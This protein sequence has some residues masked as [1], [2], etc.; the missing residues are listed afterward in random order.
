MGFEEVPQQAVRA[1][2][3]KVRGSLSGVPSGVSGPGS[4]RFL[5][6]A[7]M[8]G[9]TDFVYREVMTALFGGRSGI[10][11]C[12]CEFIRV[13]DRLLPAHVFLSHCPELATGGRTHSGVPVFV[14]LLGGQPAAMSDNA[15]RAAE[16][17]APGIDLNF[18]CPAKTVNRS[19]GGAALLREPGRVEAVTGSVRRSVPKEIPISAKLRLGWDSSRNVVELAKAAESGGADWITIHARTRVQGYAPGVEW[20]AIGRAREAVRVPVVANGDIHSADSLAICARQSGC[21][22]F[23]IGR[24]AMASPD[25]FATLRGWCESPLSF[26]EICQLL[27]DYA[28]RVLAAGFSEQKAVCRVKQWLRMGAAFRSDFHSTFERIKHARSE[29]ELISMLRPRA[30]AASEV[31]LG[32]LA[33]SAP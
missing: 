6:L 21:D 28:R 24:G 19:D 2:S 14:Q 25:L 29:S 4:S 26:P 17:G 30:L 1:V 22:A 3:S 9:V 18:G 27:V 7:P 20:E 32:R 23:M 15:L 8:D 31:S 33:A 13:I 5:A 11:A 12:T 16:L 10:S